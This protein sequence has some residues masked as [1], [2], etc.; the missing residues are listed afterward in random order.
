MNDVSSVSHSPHQRRELN[1]ET[2]EGSFHNYGVII[3][4]TKNEQGIVIGSEN[5]II[6]SIIPR[7]NYFG[8]Q[9][10]INNEGLNNVQALIR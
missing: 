2:E 5:N 7:S 9:K 4:L 3:Y 1:S 6:F 8:G 10:L